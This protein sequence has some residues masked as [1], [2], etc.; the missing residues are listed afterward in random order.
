MKNKLPEILI[1]FLLAGAE[2]IFVGVLCYLRVLNT[3]W[4][5]LI[6][7]IVLILWALFHLGLMTA[8][9]VSLRLSALDIALYLAVH[10]FYLWAWLFQSDG[11]DSGDTTWT[12]QAI[13]PIAALAPFLEKWGQ[14]LFW[15]MSIATIVCYL[16]IAILLCIHLLQFLRS[17]QV[18]AQPA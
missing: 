7:G 10:F 18:N 12:I 2:I 9:I 11:G 4:L 6:F 8:F 14:T 16:M 1:K 17:R 5:L 13:R 15:I 3:G